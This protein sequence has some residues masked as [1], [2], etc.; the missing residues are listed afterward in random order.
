MSCIFSYFCVIFFQTGVKTVAYFFQLFYEYIT[1]FSRETI[2]EVYSM[3]NQQYWD[4]KKFFE[5]L[6][7][8]LTLQK[9][10]LNSL[11]SNTDLSVNALYNM[12][13]RNTM[14][15]LQTVCII[16]DALEIDVATFFNVDNN[17]A[18][19]KIK[20]LYEQ[21]STESK[22]LLPQILRLLK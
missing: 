2:K 1:R 14:P 3:T 11:C 12:K 18:F 10:T 22:E 5:R 6:D 20:L 19:L 16:C 4:S 13:N 21:L 9:K 17:D 8:F 7:Y 15:T